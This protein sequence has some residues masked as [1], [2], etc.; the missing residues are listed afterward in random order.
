[1]EKNIEQ[2][3]QKVFDESILLDQVNSQDLVW[4]LKTLN[5]LYRAGNPLVPDDKYDEIYEALKKISPSNSFFNRVEPESSEDFASKRVEHTLPMLSLDKAYTFD[6][7][8]KFTERVQK[9][10]GDLKEGSYLYGA[11]PKL[12]GMAGNFQNDLLVTRGDGYHGFDITRIIDLG[13]IPVGGLNT[14][15]GEIVLEQ[16][17]FDKH[18]SSKFSHPRNVIVGIAGSDDINDDAENALK[19]G[20]VSFIPHIS[21]VSWKGTSNDL[22]SNFDVIMKQVKVSPYPMDGVVIEVMEEGIKSSMGSTNHHHNW[23]IA[24]KEKGQTAFSTVQSISWQL[25]R[26]GRCTPVMNIEETDL[27][28]AKIKRVTAHHAGMIKKLGI[29]KGSVIEIIRSGEVIPKIVRVMEKANDISII[30]KCPS[31]NKKLVWNN[32]FLLC[33]NH[34][35]CPQ[36]LLSRLVHFFA[37]LGNIDLL[38]HKTL[39]KIFLGGFTTLEK[40][41]SIQLQDLEGIGLGP[42]Q[43]S[44]IMGQL[45]RSRKE[46][47]NDWRFL[48]AFGIQHLGKGESKKLLK[49]YPLEALNK[50]SVEDIQNIESFGPIASPVIHKEIKLLM[51]TIERLLKKGFSLKKTEEF[52]V[53]SLSPLRNMSIVFSGKMMHDREV[54]Q[55]RALSLG[56]KVQSSINKK[57]DILIT[58]DNAG[59]KKLKKAKDLGIKILSE[60]E[61]SKMTT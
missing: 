44:N 30:N 54:M 56:A 40:I 59:E 37:V 39:E 61:Y 50:L 49:E 53:S 33:T 10:A 32:D 25:G 3:I 16:E 7:I 36:Q 22:L 48:A 19:E 6:E 55:D 26:T 57:T 14:G 4:A 41:Y 18:L 52:K 12:D 5:K 17:F 35:S 58:G 46:E 21:L 42:K 28:G 34:A 24:Y 11:S 47:I 43:A 51:P 38:G 29:G 23:Q 1:M 13:V 60:K 8:L 27:S 15:Q 45:I 20:A 31:C 2:F 9:H